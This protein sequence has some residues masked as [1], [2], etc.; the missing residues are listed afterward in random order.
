MRS[1]CQGLRHKVYSADN[2]TGTLERRLSN[3]TCSENKRFSRLFAN[4]PIVFIQ[5]Q[6]AEKKG[7]SERFAFSKRYRTFYVFRF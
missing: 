2:Q 6:T 3:H 5:V 1:D 4:G 7:T